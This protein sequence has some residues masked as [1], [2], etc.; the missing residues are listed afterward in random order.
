MVSKHKRRD[1]YW[2]Y[3]HLAHT[4]ER[5]FL[6]HHIVFLV[7][8]NPPPIQKKKSKLGRKLVHSKTKMYC[9]CV[10]M[11]LFG[12]TYRDMQ[13]IIPSLNLP[14]GEPYP[15]HTTIARFFGRI[16]TD[17]LEQILVRTAQMCLAECGWEKGILSSDS[18]AVSTDLYRHELRP[19]KNRHKF[20]QIKIRQYLKWHVTAILDHLVILSSRITGSRT[21]DSPVL[22][23][24][25]NKMRKLGIDLKGSLFDAD[26]GYDSDDRCKQIFEM[27][28]LPN[29]SQRK[30]AVN[31]NKRFRRQAAKIFDV[32]VYHYRGLIEGIFGAE[33]SEHHQMYCRYKKRSNQQRWGQMKSIGWN[34]EVLN[35]LQCAAKLGIEVKQYEIAN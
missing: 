29:I 28:M 3:Y 14:W 10:L 35:R 24:M 7:N 11:V 26:K 31:R 20:E 16:S 32:A 27:G 15:D 9:I 34:L 6:A 33:E 30:N 23:T 19:V 25:L 5:D 8:E 12:V 22:K 2:K 4:Q 1:G 18:T 13:N 17:W 21:H